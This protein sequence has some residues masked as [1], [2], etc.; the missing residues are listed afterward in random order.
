M[1][2]VA[3][4]FLWLTLLAGG[5]NAQQAG[6]GWLGVELKDLTKAEADAL[7]WEVPRGAKLVK[8]MPGGPAEAAGLQPGDILVSLDGVEIES[9]KALTETMSKKAAGTEIKLAI[10]RAGREKRLALKL[11]ARPAQ[12]AAAKPAADA[13][14]PML[15]TGGRLASSK[16]SGLRRTASSWS[17]PPR[18]RAS[19]WGSSERQERAQDPGRERA[20]P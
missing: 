6:A 17:R 20:G 13:P 12:L 7:G 11:G 3:I 10:L 5:A 4:A 1:R 9:V 18:S 8:P 19:A 14:L 2:I 16:A 15:D